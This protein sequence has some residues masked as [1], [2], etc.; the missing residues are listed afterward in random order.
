MVWTEEFA[1]P[2]PARTTIGARLFPPFRVELDV[3]AWLDDTPEPS[4][5]SGPTA[6]TR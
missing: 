3:V 2:P 6:W 4:A 1:E 5:T